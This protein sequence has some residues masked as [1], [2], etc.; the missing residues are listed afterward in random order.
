MAHKY[1]I[2]DI[3]AILLTN[4]IVKLIQQLKI[5]LQTYLRKL[6]LLQNIFN[7]YSRDIIIVFHS[8]NLKNFSLY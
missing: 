2:I 5:Y 3:V 7:I 4:N 8:I 6:N 1:Y